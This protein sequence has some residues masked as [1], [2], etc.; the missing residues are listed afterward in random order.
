[1]PFANFTVGQVFFAVVHDHIRPPLDVFK[2][3]IEKSEEE[4]PVLEAYVALLQ[5]CWAEKGSERPSFPAI[6]S[7]LSGLRAQVA[8]LRSASTP[9]G[10][11]RGANMTSPF[12]QSPPATPA[13]GTSPTTSARPPPARPPPAKPP[14]VQPSAPAAEAGEGLSILRS[15]SF[16]AQQAGRPPLSPEESAGQPPQQ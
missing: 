2:E 9:G 15:P 12:A 13:A 4:R 5:R 16:E 11:R 7:E 10:G 3:A 8:Q 14:P 1:M 6:L